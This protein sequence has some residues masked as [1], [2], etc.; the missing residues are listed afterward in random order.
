M[1]R[2]GG[3]LSAPAGEI[4]RS[5]AAHDLAALIPDHLLGE[6]RL[7]GCGGFDAGLDMPDDKA[8]QRFIIGCKDLD[9]GFRF[10]KL[11]AD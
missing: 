2:G 4:A 7:G 1:T 10:C 5:P 8:V 3:C 9:F 6:F 11:F